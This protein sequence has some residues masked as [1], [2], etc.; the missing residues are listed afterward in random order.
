VENGYLQLLET[1]Q[2]MVIM[3]MLEQL[4]VMLLMQLLFQVEMNMLFILK[5]E[6][7]CLL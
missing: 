3:D 6:T 5:E 4:M 7:G 2:T 1:M